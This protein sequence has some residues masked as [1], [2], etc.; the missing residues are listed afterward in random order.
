[1]ICSCAAHELW[2]ADSVRDDHDCALAEKNADWE[3]KG[4]TL[5]S[6]N[7]MARYLTLTRIN[8]VVA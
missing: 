7:R 2:L 1:M 8:T 4:K 3:F 6:I 5:L